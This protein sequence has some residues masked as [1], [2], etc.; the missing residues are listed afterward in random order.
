VLGHRG[1]VVKQIGDGFMLAFRDPVDAV[2]ATIAL[3]EQLTAPGMPSIR[4]GINTGL[5]V[6]RASDY[7]GSTVNIASRVTTAAG[8][9]QL[10]VTATTA[11]QIV[12]SDVE[13]EAL[14]VRLLRGVDEPIALF[15]V[16]KP[17]H[18]RDPVCG[19]LV[20]S[21]HAVRLGTG[22]RELLFCSQQCLLAYLNKT[23]TQ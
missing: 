3:H 14:G 16:L 8:P 5:A 19:Q 13:V 23:P 7:I 6:Y 17:R 18:Q 1:K 15:R 11:E 22:D 10:L 20:A 12:D 21:D 4:V 2:T 9:G